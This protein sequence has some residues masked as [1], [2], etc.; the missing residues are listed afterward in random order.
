MGK[1]F[2]NVKTYPSKSM[3]FRE[4]IDAIM[5]VM[6]DILPKIN[7]DHAPDR[8]SFILCGQKEGSKAHRIVSFDL[9]A[10]KDMIVT[11][12]LQLTTRETAVVSIEKA[13][14]WPNQDCAYC[15]SAQANHFGKMPTNI[16]S[17]FTNVKMESTGADLVWN[18]L[19]LNTVFGRFVASFQIYPSDTDT[20]MLT[21]RRALIGLTEIFRQL[22]KEDPILQTQSAD[23]VLQED[24]IDTVSQ[25]RRLFEDCHLPA[26]QR[27]KAWHEP[28]NQSGKLALFFG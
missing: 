25:V 28:A 10:G 9:S 11:P 22:G 5:E 13:L 12:R 23:L 8:G 17:E 15:Y 20:N 3:L 26:L 21:M 1:L 2:T 7:N 16:Y 19:V 27:W 24:S 6:G 4:E 14:Q 18:T